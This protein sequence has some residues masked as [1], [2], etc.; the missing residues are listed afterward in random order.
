MNSN[1]G[2]MNLLF[3]FCNSQL[4]NEFLLNSLVVLSV[5]YVGETCLHAIVYRLKSTHVSDIWHATNQAY[6]GI[7]D[8][9][10]KFNLYFCVCFITVCKMAEKLQPKNFR[11]T[12]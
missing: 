1:C 3:K 2:S 6:L 10:F 5:L 7:T 4:P 12:F 8:Q 11:V 9:L